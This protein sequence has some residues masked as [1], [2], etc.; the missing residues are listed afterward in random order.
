MRQKLLNVLYTKFH[1][2]PH[3]V[4]FTELTT[5]LWVGYYHRHLTHEETE[6]QRGLVI[7][8]RSQS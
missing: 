4:S 6:A 2:L 8:S 1:L 5:A 3:F 7:K